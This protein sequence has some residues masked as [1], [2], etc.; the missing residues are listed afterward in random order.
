M[1]GLSFALHV[2]LVL[3]LVSTPWR[4]ADQGPQLL[5]YSVDLVPAEHLGGRAAP[6]GRTDPGKPASVLHAPP[7]KVSVP[8]PESV[9]PK[10]DPPKANVAPAPKAA[11]REAAAKKPPQPK[12]EPAKA[13]PP[14][15]EPAKPAPKPP[16]PEIDPV[17]PKPVEKAPIAPPKPDSKPKPEPEPKPQAEK[18][19]PVEAAAAAEDSTRPPVSTPKQTNSEPRSPTPGV[20]AEPDPELARRA[21]AQQLRDEQLAAAVERLA[22]RTAPSRVEPN[23]VGLG[24][25]GEGGMV[26]GLEFMLYKGIVESLVRQSWAW[27]GSNR[28]LHAVVGFGIEADGQVVDVG[29][30]RSSG[31]ATYD[32]LAR[33]AVES[34]S[35][36]PPPPA[37][38]R[39]AFRR[40]ELELR[41]DGGG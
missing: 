15:P 8:K 14:K 39:E 18:P 10:A 11:P 2:G 30:V 20:A 35:P 32:T 31:D 28:N 36:L 25:E 5:S 1:F 3:L 13:A 40:Y 16:E 37:A 41:A 29:I 24:G 26:Q 17:R 27:S 6:S 9:P 12:P 22:G 23:G 21:V 7:P 38:Y 34:V 4:T 19:K 33:R